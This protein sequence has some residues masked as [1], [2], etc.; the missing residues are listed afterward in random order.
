MGVNLPEWLH[1]RLV[2]ALPANERERLM[3]RADILNLARGETVHEPG[4]P[5]GSIYFPLSAVFSLVGITLEGETVELCHVGSEGIVGVSALSGSRRIY[6]PRMLRTD[7]RLPGRALRIS[8][9][10]LSALLSAGSRLFSLFVWYLNILFGHLA[11]GATCN[12]HHSLQRRCI[13]WLLSMQDRTDL[14][15]IQITQENMAELLGVRRQSID[16]VLDS[17]ER[18]GL[19]GCSRGRISMIDRKGLEAAVCECYFI[20]RQAFECFPPTEERPL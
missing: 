11:M 1:N 18:E 5:V 10:K 12:Q 15:H 20:A 8:R 2:F 17:I 14:P 3:A 7:V 19:I 9:E 16:I 4:E 13:R 6:Q